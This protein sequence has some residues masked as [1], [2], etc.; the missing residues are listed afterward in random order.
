[1]KSLILTMLLKK[2]IKKL[3]REKKETYIRGLTTNSKKVEKGFIFFAIKGNKA[4]GGLLV[5]PTLVKSKTKK[6]NKRLIQK[7][8]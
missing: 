7:K 4:N 2:L 8:N 6:N 5:K 1:M 3:S